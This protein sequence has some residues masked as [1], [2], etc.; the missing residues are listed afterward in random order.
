M[1]PMLVPYTVTEPVQ[2]Q[3]GTALSG[4]AVGVFRDQF[5]TISLPHESWIPRPM[6]IFFT[7]M[8]FSGSTVENARRQQ[9]DRGAVLFCRKEDYDYRKSRSFRPPWERRI[10][11]Q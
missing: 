1:R 5:Y 2:G 9:M 10:S 11:G 6:R 8:P 3:K 7:M 4:Y